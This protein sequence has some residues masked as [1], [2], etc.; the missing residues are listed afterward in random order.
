VCGG[1]V[2]SPALLEFVASSDLST[3]QLTSV[4]KYPIINNTAMYHGKTA[5]NMNETRAHF[6][7]R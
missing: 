1:R 2:S 7:R 4:A 5:K 6:A 3:M